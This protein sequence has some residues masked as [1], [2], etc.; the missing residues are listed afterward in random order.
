MNTNPP[1]II[2][3]NNRKFLNI[4]NLLLIIVLL[5]TSLT[6][7][8]L[9]LFKPK[10]IEQSA[11]TVTDEEGTDIEQD[12]TTEPN[13][14]CN[15]KHIGDFIWESYL[16]TNHNTLYY[17]EVKKDDNTVCNHEIYKEKKGEII[18]HAYLH[19][20]EKKVSFFLQKISDQGTPL[21]NTVEYYIADLKENTVKNTNILVPFNNYTTLYSEDGSYKYIILY[22]TTSGG[23]GVDNY[24]ECMAK[25][26]QDF[27]KFWNESKIYILNTDGEKYEIPCNTLPFTSKFMIEQSSS[28]TLLVIDDLK[29]I[30]TYQLDT[31]FK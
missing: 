12:I 6:F 30:K 21:D 15:T 19:I 4:L 22:P 2:T 29:V 20:D 3:S 9:Y 7:G 18:Q 31:I 28:P 5:I 27:K 26:T 16:Y 14:I 23:C 24:E 13:P 10:T 1:P 17:N 25:V 8:Y 11:D